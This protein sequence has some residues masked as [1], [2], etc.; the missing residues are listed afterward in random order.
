MPGSR[1]PHSGMPYL[2]TSQKCSLLSPDPVTPECAGLLSKVSAPVGEDTS[3]NANSEQ[4][5]RMP[6]PQ[7]AA[8]LFTA[9]QIE[10]ALHATKAEGPL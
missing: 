2:A 1:E 7:G 4:G 6:V 8:H 3:C 5:L 10:T 9:Q